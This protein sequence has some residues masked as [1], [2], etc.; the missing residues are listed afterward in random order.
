MGQALAIA[1]LLLKDVDARAQRLRVLDLGC[2]MGLTGAAAAAAGHRVLFAD[3]ERPALLFAALNSLPYRRRVRT[4][5]LDWRV[6]LLHEQFDLIIGADILYERSQWEYLEPFW[7]K[8]L[9]DG[10]TVLLGEPGRQ[11]GDLFQPWI[12][13]RGWSLEVMHHPVVTRTQPIRLFRLAVGA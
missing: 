1:E 13:S 3:L 8:H 10:G 5:E 2:G 9:C 6:D 4:R 11:S 12:R 7:R